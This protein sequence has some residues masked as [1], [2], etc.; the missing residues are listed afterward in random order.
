VCAAAR[1][2][3]AIRLAASARALPAPAWLAALAAIAALACA[4]PPPPKPAPPAVPAGSFYWEAS[5]P[6]GGQLYLLGSVH[7]G[8]G[9]AL[10]L[11]PRVESAWQRAAELV[12]EVDTSALSPVDALATINRYGLM[13]PEQSL[14]D[15]VSPDTYE[16]LRAY[17]KKRHYPIEAANRM[18]PWLLAQVVSQLEYQAAGYDA[19]NGV[20]VWFLRR[21]AGKPIVELESI[22]EQTALFASLPDALQEKLLR[23]VLGN[24]EDFIAVTQAILRAWE[25]GDEDALAALVLGSRDDPELATFYERVFTE[26][27]RR[28]SERLATLAADGKARF[29]VIGAGHLIGPESVPVLLVQRGFQVQRVADA[30][31][32]AHGAGAPAAA[33]APAR[34]PASSGSTHVPGRPR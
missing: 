19:E 21:A 30:R 20:D 18:R 31:L 24:T 14:H 23:E 11:D 33:P 8:D 29:V 28:M 4:K 7:I 34:P 3:R 5:A 25:Q 9:R 13:P 15:V 22:D 12:V 26:R 16:A 6:G 17:L 1:R 10:E 32:R 27:N 2:L